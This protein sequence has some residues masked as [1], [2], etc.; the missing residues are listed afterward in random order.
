VKDK[1]IRY[2]RNKETIGVAANFSK[3]FR[4][5]S[6]EYFKWAACDDVIAPDFLSK[7]IEI[8]DEDRNIV[9]CHTKTGCIDELGELCGSYDLKIE[10]NSLKYH[11]LFGELIS[12]NNKA[13]LLIY[14]LIRSDILRRTQLMGDYIGSD[15]NLLAELSLFGRF[16]EISECLFFRRKHLQSY[17]DKMAFRDYAEKLQWWTKTA[18][19]KKTIFPYWK[20]CLEYFYSVYKMPLSWTERLQCGVRIIRWLVEEGWFYMGSDIG[21][22]LTKLSDKAPIIVEKLIPLAKWLYRHTIRKR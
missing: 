2:Y 14:G 1:R 13:W 5:S 15:R 19:S 17:T 22:N 9:L 21:I 6:T 12:M 3:V 7:C 18:T 8:L 10:I 11:K 20:I 16:Y 4:L